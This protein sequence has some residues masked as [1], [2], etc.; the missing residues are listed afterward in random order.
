[1]KVEKINIDELIEKIKQAGYLPGARIDLNQLQ[2]LCEKYG[3]GLEEVD[4]AVRVLGITQVSYN[5]MKYSAQKAQILQFKK[6]TVRTDEQEE[7]KKKIIE[8][9][10]YPGQSIDYNQ[11]NELYEKYG[12]KFKESDFAFIILG[13]NYSNYYTCKQR[14]SRVIIF[15]Q[16]EKLSEE[17]IQK[18][19]NEIKDSGYYEGKL[20]DYEELQLLYKKYGKDMSE[21]VFAMQILGISYNMYISCKANRNKVRILNIERTILTN[22][23]IEKIIEQIKSLGYYQ[24]QILN[25]DE[26]HNLYENYGRGLNEKDFAYK[27][28]GI[29]DGNYRTCKRRGTRVKIFKE[30]K[31]LTEKERLEIINELKNA[32]YYSGQSIDEKELKQLTKEYG[33]GLRE[34]DFACEILGIKEGT[35]YSFKG[36][37]CRVQILKQ[38]KLISE[39]EI[40]NIVE[41]L[42]SKGWCSGQ[43][44]DYEKLKEIYNIYGQKRGLSEKDFANEVLNIEGY[45]YNF[46]KNN[47]GAKAKILTA[48][49]LT[50]KDSKQILNKIIE[51]GYD[52][53]QLIDYEEFQVLFARYGNGLNE[54]DFAMQILN[55][56][57]T[58]YFQLKNGRYK[59]RILKNKVPILT[60][61]ERKKIIDEI[62]ENGYIGTSVNYKDFR[63]LYKKYREIYTEK[64]FAFE[65]LGIN[66]PNYSRCKNSGANIVIK[67]GLLIQ[68]SREIKSLYVNQAR[69]YSKSEI[70]SICKEYDITID[71]FLTYVYQEN[72]YDT[73]PFKKVL[74]RKKQLWIGRTRI[75]KE[76]VDRNIDKINQIALEIS[77]SVCKKY[78]L[79]QNRDDYKQNLII[80]VIE[81][82]GDLEK[83]LGDTDEFFDIV[84]RK[85]RKFCEGDTLEKFRISKR[86][87]GLYKVS[88]NRKNINDE[89]FEVQYADKSIDIEQTVEDKLTRE[90]SNSNENDMERCIDLLKNCI[91]SGMSK[92]KAIEET[93]NL[94]NIDSQQ[95]LKLMQAYL[96]QKG[97]VKKIKGKVMLIEE[98]E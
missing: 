48:E 94:M 55:I 84:G 61:E 70:D 74:D 17:K 35:Y 83:N 5:G 44:I 64:D 1:M 52:I 63:K 2:K 89:I 10:Y 56:S 37:K 39:E 71:D 81:N 4:F 76:F 91:E 92:R 97:K 36:K 73:S 33:R 96:I 66:Y 85:T 24:N 90:D 34:K 19:V 6:N 42:K 43:Y 87:E 32:G 65:I 18:L 8:E 7:V 30:E 25:Y 40:L 29:K 57:E 3:R 23:E 31:G 93:S 27:I 20:I 13:V 86:F 53:G 98:R 22:E 78:H 15:K 88:K 12:K 9:G 67:D 60:Y 51:E 26:L 54:K 38:E 68:K 49:K 50:D 21:K 41:L 69:Y 80:Y 14:K 95:M 79:N 16:E 58:G 47:K 59:V 75:S 72:F 28:L 46:I 82:M 45:R 77:T 62:K 11:L